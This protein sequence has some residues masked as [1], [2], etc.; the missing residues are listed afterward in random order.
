M[1]LICRNK[2]KI[3]GMS[4]GI[5]GSWRHLTQG[6]ITADDLTLQL[7]ILEISN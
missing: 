3:I 2:E 1:K 6:W 4:L 5:S 7:P